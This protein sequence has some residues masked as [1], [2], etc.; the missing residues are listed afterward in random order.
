MWSTSFGNLTRSYVR[1]VWSLRDRRLDGFFL[2][3][4]GDGDDETWPSRLCSVAAVS[5]LYVTLSA[6]VGP[7]LMR[8]RSPFQL[9]TAVLAYNALQVTLLKAMVAIALFCFFY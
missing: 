5:S 1:S 9:K 7:A 4:E 3:G 2:M 6:A 8:S